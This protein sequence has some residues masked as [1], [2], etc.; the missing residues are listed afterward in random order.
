MDVPV[1]GAEEAIEGTF[2]EPVVKG[3]RRALAGL[4]R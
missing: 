2:L 1:A 3:S 4:D